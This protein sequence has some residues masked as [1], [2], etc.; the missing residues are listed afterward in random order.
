MATS[1][2][3]KGGLGRWI[4]RLL[5]FA[6][7]ILLLPYALVPVYRLD[8]VKPV[9][10]LMLYDLMRGED[11]RREWVEFEAIAPV[12]VQS[13]MMSEDGR[14]CAHDGVD[15]EALNTVIAGTL[16]G[17][18]TRGAST[19]AMQTVKNLFLWQSRSFVRKGLEV[20]LAL[21]ADYVWPKRRT[22]ELYL[23][24]AQFAPDVYGVEAAAKHHFGVGASELTARQ[25]ALLAVSLPNPFTRDAGRPSD[26]LQ[27]L[28]AT[29][30]QRARQS[31]AYI[32]CLYK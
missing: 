14:F 11:Y 7:L 13:V 3:G 15:W 29:I 12:L 30:E 25:A 1:R 21:A 4:G 8:S 23:N 6:L 2:R 17:E 31:G 10:T 27:A 16:D 19:I 24:V 9:S 22:M 28:A 32:T 26:G 20:P 5:L 18:Q